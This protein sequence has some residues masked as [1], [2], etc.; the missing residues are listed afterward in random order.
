MPG[1]QTTYT[2]EEMDAILKRAIERE[3]A[4]SE[5][6]SRD[7]LI[8]AAAEVGIAPEEVEAAARELDAKKA[9]NAAGDQKRRE[10][11]AVVD[12]NRARAIRRFWRQAVTYAGLSLFFFAMNLQTHARWWIWAVLGMGLSLSFRAAK[13]FFGEHDASDDGMSRRERRRTRREFKAHIDSAVD[14][15][16][17][18]AIDARIGRHANTSTDTAKPR[19][20]EPS[21]RV[22]PREDDAVDRAEDTP[23]AST[24]TSRRS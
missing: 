10:S 12:E 16:V 7:E 4:K 22:E 20:V 21:V 19:V 18:S 14:E 2:R 3:Q 15:L 17:R 5:G 1:P 8:A 6:I 9:E 13:T 24:R 11:L 23:G